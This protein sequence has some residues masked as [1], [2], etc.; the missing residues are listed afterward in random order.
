MHADA[1][2]PRT[3][4][5]NDVARL[6]VAE[7]RALQELL[8]VFQ[9]LQQRLEIGHHQTRRAA[10]HLWRIAGR[11]MELAAADIHPHVLEP[12]HQ[13]RIA[14]EPKAHQV[15]GDR[16]RLVG[17][18]DVDMPKLNDVAEILGRAIELRPG[19]NRVVHSWDPLCRFSIRWR[20]IPPARGFGPWGGKAALRR[21]DDRY[22]AGKA[23]QRNV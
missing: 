6:P 19:H 3:A 10:H 14:R 8:R 9:P 16:L 22:G 11:Q 15:E 17:H 12:G 18:R 23:M 21:V 20:M 13:I 7:L 4:R 1:V 5:L 2:A